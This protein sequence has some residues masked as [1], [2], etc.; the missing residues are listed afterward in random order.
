MKDDI[1]DKLESMPAEIKKSDT[2]K[3]SMAIALDNGTAY[4]DDMYEAVSYY[5]HLGFTPEE[6]CNQTN[7]GS[8]NT[9]TD[10]IIKLIYNRRKKC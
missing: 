9:D 2:W 7:F 4:Y 1:I 8:L 5:L 3:I 10:E 6:I